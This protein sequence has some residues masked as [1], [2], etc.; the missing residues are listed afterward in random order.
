MAERRKEDT[1]EESRGISKQKWYDEKKKKIGRQLEAQ[2]LEMKKA[3][4]LDTQEE[5]EQK[6]KKWEKKEAAFGWDGEIWVG[7]HMVGCRQCN[8]RGHTC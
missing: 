5:A 2:G 1:P 7:H 8:A 4:M 6:Y 3:F